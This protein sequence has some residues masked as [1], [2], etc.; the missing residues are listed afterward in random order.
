MIA[1][2]FMVVCCNLESQQETQL[3]DTFG[4]S[5]F[6]QVDNFFC[7]FQHYTQFQMDQEAQKRK[8]RLAA[9][10]KRKLGSAAQTDR[11]TEEAEK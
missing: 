9:I 5:N 7:S 10:R 2:A 11:T 3:L 4:I 8:E 6:A 1:I